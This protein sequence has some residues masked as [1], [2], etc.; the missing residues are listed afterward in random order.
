MNEG[1]G[2]YAREERKVILL[3]H[4]LV[5]LRENSIVTTGMNPVMMMTGMIMRFGVGKTADSGSNGFI[6]G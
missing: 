3:T 2:Q 1:L 6:T 5:C 4:Y